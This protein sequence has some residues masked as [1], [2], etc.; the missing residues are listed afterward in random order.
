MLADLTTFG[1]N[2]TDLDAD[3]TSDDQLKVW[4]IKFYPS[5]VLDRAVVRFTD[6]TGQGFTTLQNSIIADPVIEYFPPAFRGIIHFDYSASVIT[7]P[8]NAR[9]VI[10]FRH[11]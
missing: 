9:L 11:Y 3:Y 5:N 7:T 1:V 6:G 10:I 2:I 8:A 4:S